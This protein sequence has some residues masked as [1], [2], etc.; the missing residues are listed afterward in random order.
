MK[1][2]IRMEIFAFPLIILAVAVAIWIMSDG[3]GRVFA[4]KRKAAEAN[5]RAEEAKLQRAKLERGV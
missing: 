5:A 3:P 2:V 4:D 1:V